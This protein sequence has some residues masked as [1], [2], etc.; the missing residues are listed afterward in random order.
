MEITD[1]TREPVGV[2]SWSSRGTW[3]SVSA[4]RV[5]WAVGGEYS[6][7][8]FGTGC[9]RSVR[10]DG[11]LTINDLALPSPPDLMDIYANLIQRLERSVAAIGGEEQEG[12]ASGEPKNTT[13][14][15]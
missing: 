8:E 12:T 3:L 2:Y 15:S 9:L 6:S 4:S 5:S 14:G 13:G 11:G 7:I 10:I 1:R